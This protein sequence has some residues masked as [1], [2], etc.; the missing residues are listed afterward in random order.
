MV[1][2]AREAG[3]TKSEQEKQ[4]LALLRWFKEDLFTWVNKLPCDF[5]KV[6][7]GGARKLI[8]QEEN[9]TLARVESANSSESPGDCSRV[10]V[11]QCTRCNNL[12]RFPR[13]K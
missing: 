12:S 5:C 6:K 4:I 13:F 9:T 8:E 2:V 10:E 1:K 7:A 11:Y 3:T